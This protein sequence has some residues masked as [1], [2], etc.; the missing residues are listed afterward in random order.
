ML[1][2]ILERQYRT[3]GEILNVLSWREWS[4]LK[5]VLC[6]EAILDRQSMM[7]QTSMLRSQ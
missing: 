6:N 5:E 1:R 7:W 2:P 4:T 3:L